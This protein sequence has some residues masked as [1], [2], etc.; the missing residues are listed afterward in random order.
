MRWWGR[1]KRS[2][3]E[4]R[5]KRFARWPK[6]HLKTTFTSKHFANKWPESYFLKLTFYL[7]TFAGFQ[8]WLAIHGQVGSVNIVVGTFVGRIYWLITLLHNSSVTFHIVYCTMLSTS[9]PW[10]C[11][12]FPEAGKVNIVVAIFCCWSRLIDNDVWENRAGKKTT[13]HPL[14]QMLALARL[15]IYPSVPTR[16]HIRTRIHIHIHP[17][18]KL[19]L[20]SRYIH[21]FPSKIAIAAVHYQTDI[22]R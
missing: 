13:T 14:A 5:V 10:S 21:K 7:Q 6:L 11:L 19:I 16:I 3:A 12:E 9:Y 2:W 4:T 15:S 8:V 17:Y 1:H 20:G 18:S 22:L